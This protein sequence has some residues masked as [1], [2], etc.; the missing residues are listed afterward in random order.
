MSWK[1]L[2]QGR[3]EVQDWKLTKVYEEPGQGS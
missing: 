3:E 2:H 1:N